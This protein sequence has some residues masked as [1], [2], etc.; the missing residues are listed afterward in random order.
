MIWTACKVPGDVNNVL[1]VSQMIRNKYKKDVTLIASGKAVDIL[2][3]YGERFLE[4][5]SAEAFIDTHG[6]P[7]AFITGMGAGALWP[8]FVPLLSS[9][10]P[11][12]IL[13]DYWGNG[14]FTDWADLLYRPDY[15]C[16]NDEIDLNW[17]LKAWPEF[18]PGRIVVTGYSH[19]DQYAH[20]DVRVISEKV[21]DKL[22]L[23]SKKPIIL[24]LGEREETAHALA[25]LVAVMNDFDVL[26]GS[27]Y[28]FVPRF[29]PCM[30]DDVPLE[31][32]LCEEVLSGFKGGVLVR[33]SSVCTT[34]ELIASASLVVSMC[35]TTLAEASI[36]RKPNISLLYPDHG[37]KVF[38][39]YTNGVMDESPFVST[40]CS[41][42]AENRE[43]L[44]RL[45][46]DK[47]WFESQVLSQEK[48]FVLDSQ[49]TLRAAGVVMRTMDGRI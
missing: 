7:E 15:I 1:P 25:E 11:I 33:D 6:Y 39:R 42:K 49:N 38:L 14:I 37:Q 4:V 8:S 24:F 22:K 32:A 47:S 9:K 27:E 43:Q 29:H 26:D 45:L 17:V 40:R 10:C 5:R 19:F 30:K 34:T 21:Q 20:L 3:N 16:V 2:A 23:D 31:F 46:K 35:S 12:I 41:V 18:N 48:T 44:I 28:Y 13:Q 36:L